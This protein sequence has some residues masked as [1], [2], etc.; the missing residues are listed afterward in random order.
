MSTSTEKLQELEA[1]FGDYR[2]PIRVWF[3][4]YISTKEF[5]DQPARAKESILFFYEE[6]MKAI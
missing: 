6:L 3:T 5:T 2:E 1:F 4:A